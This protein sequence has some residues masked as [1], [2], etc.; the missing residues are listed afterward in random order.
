VKNRGFVAR[1]GFAV[2]GWRAAWRSEASFRTQFCMMVLAAVALLVL[3]PAP[4]WWAL[5]LL[6][7][8]AVLAL[9]LANSAVEAVID[10]L[11]PEIHPSIKVAKDM[12]AGAVL[13]MSFAA[14]AVG[15]AMVVDRG[16]GFLAEVGVLR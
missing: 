7:S 6:V 13:V 12:L 15:L 4:V 9:E 10:L 11:H 5:I 14:L 8:A 2:S 16:P 1:V 3:R